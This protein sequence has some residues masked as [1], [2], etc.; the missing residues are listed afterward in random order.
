MDT[1]H[2]TN[3]EPFKIIGDWEAQ[4]RQLKA[5]YSILTDADLVYEAGKEELL[6]TR[7]ESRLKK[8]RTEVIDILKKCRPH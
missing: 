1:T 5:K 3:G 8:R 4:V 7:I 2:Q 6:L